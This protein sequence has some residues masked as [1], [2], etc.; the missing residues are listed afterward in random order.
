MDINGN[1]VS[2]RANGMKFIDNECICAPN[3][4][5]FLDNRMF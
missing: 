1:F 3:S 5:D 4:T 2:C